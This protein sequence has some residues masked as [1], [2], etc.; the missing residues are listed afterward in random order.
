MES[1]ERAAVVSPGVRG[2]CAVLALLLVG[3]AWL[4]PL[5]R[6]VVTFHVSADGVAQYRG[7]EVVTVVAAV[8]LALIAL[9]GPRRPYVALT[10][11][12]GIAG[13]VGYTFVTVIVGQEYARYPGDA[14]RAFPLYAA[15]TGG[16]VI[17][18]VLA[19]QRLR[20]LPPVPVSRAL[21]RTTRAVLIGVI[22]VVALAWSAQIAAVLVG[23][24]MPEYD[25]DTTLFWLIKLL[26]FGFLLPLTGFLVAS[27]RPGRAVPYSV[28]MLVFAVCLTAAIASMA[29]GQLHAGTAQG[30]LQPQN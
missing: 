16:S 4:G 7:G 5:G 27:C 13:Y 22:V 6:S 24:G 18:G 19:I 20:S 29:L 28:P 12:M 3:A 21:A 9:V 8:A 10:A 11:A 2:L 15:L 14:E 26:D 25:R 23:G 17:L 1:S 30:I